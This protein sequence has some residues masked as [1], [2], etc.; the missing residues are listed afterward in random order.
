PPGFEGCH[1][2]G[3]FR[4]NRLENLRW[5]SRKNNMND[6]VLHNTLLKGDRHP[7]TK[8]KELDK[9]AIRLLLRR[10]YSLRRIAK[11][12]GFCTG[13]VRKAKTATATTTRGTAKGTTNHAN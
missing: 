1:N 13:T 4:N 6:K 11:F 8:M 2:D 9:A 3:D 10:G 7:N 12:F 5:D